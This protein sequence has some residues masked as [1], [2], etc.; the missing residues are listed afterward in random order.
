MK[1]AA[2]SILIGLLATRAL[3]HPGGAH[4]H[5]SLGFIE[6]L[7]LTALPVVVAAG[8]IGLAVYAYLRRA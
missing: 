7:V 3:A 8:L 4:E 5:E 2:L 1:K 6:H